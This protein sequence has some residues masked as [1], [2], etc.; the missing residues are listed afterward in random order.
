MVHLQVREAAQAVARA[1]A[2]VVLHPILLLQPLVLVYQEP[3]FTMPWRLV[4]LM[5]WRLKLIPSM[6]ACAIQLLV[7]NSTIISGVPACRKTRAIGVILKHLLSAEL[8]VLACHLQVR[9][10]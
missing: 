9:I 5:L 2:Q 3:I 6:C 4:M 10:K 1:R 7:D 8:K